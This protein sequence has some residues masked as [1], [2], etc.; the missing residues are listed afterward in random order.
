MTLGKYSKI[1][2]FL[3]AVAQWQSI[4]LWMRG[5]WVQPP[6]AT[7]KIQDLMIEVLFHYLSDLY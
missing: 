6:S 5:L 7:P 2:T 1:L 4:A 3:V